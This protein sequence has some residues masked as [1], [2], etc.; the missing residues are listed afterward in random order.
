MK[1]TIT[2]IFIT[3]SVF[4]LFWLTGIPALFRVLYPL[5]ITKIEQKYNYR[6]STNDLVFKTSLPAKFNISAKNLYI[7]IVLPTTNPTIRASFIKM[8]L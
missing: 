5:A 4:C 6:V 8:Y 1:R 3:I 7:T 2:I